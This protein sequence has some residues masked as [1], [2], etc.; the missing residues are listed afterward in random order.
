WGLGLLSAG[1][2]LV[3]WLSAGGCAAWDGEGRCDAVEGS[4][5]LYPSLLILGLGVTMTA[6][7]WQSLE[8]R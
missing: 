4:P 5:P 7:F 6:N 8:E 3:G 1:V 2:G